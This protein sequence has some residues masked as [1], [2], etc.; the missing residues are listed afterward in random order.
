[1]DFYLSESN[2]LT[3]YGNVDIPQF[4]S[5]SME[6]NNV[7]LNITNSNEVQYNTND[8]SEQFG[9]YKCVIAAGEITFEKTIFLRNKGKY[10]LNSYYNSCSLLLTIT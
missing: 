3:C 9:V 4:L 8:N 2:H 5:I 7:T 10:C 1:M 6:K